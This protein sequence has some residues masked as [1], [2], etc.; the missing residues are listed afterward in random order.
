MPLSNQTRCFCKVFARLAKPY[1]YVRNRRQCIQRSS[2]EETGALAVLH[3]LILRKAEFHAPV[4][5]ALHSESRLTNLEPFCT[6]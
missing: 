1:E 4:V 3:I 5:Q 6:T 2:N